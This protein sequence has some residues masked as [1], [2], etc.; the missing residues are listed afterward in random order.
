MAR[1]LIPVYKRRYNPN[2]KGSSTTQVLMPSDNPF[3][4][5]TSI[6]NQSR[7]MMPGMGGLGDIAPVA[8]ASTGINWGAITQGAVT[9]GTQ[10]GQVALTNAVNKILPP[11]K[12]VPMQYPQAQPLP[13]S[14]S[15]AAQKKSILPWAIG[16]G[17]LVLGIGALLMLRGK[18]R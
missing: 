5:R 12:P 9:A 14:Y 6:V 16:G 1:V 11:P 8:P 13:M 18:K 7:T 10:V 2:P 3:E 4:R 15:P 17:V